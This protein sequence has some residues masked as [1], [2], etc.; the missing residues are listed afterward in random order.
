MIRL[1][2]T[3]IEIIDGDRQPC[4]KMKAAMNKTRV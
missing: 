1:C 4:H 2:D 3:D